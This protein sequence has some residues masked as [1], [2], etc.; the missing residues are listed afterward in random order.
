VAIVASRAVEIRRLLGALADPKTRPGALLRLRAMGARVVPHIDEDLSRLD[1]HTRRALVD[2]LE[3]VETQDGKALRKRL[4]RADSAPTAEKPE[5]SSLAP[6][7][8]VADDDPE[9]E[10]LR[11]LKGLP[12]PKAG[13][14]AGVSRERGEAHLSLARL[15][16]RLARKDLFDTLS[17]LDPGRL[18]LCCEAAGLVGDAAFL[19]PLARL[20]DTLPEAADAI[21]R[22]AKRE[23]ITG[24]SKHLAALDE[25]SRLAV[26]RAL[27][28]R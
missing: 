28:S 10:A 22:V 26:A 9:T 6:S 25:P 4:L 11:V 19:A 5:R 2:V 1:I 21:A 7:K 14:R 27:A 23:R 8:A 17:I 3:G 15:G 24:R 16:S 20:A 12:P 13:E 18:R